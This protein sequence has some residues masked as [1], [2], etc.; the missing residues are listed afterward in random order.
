LAIYIYSQQEKT[1]ASPPDLL[2]LH[3]IPKDFPSFALCELER[4][5]IEDKKKLDLA[6]TQAIKY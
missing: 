3:S 6:T 5:E 4:E 1:A 2:V